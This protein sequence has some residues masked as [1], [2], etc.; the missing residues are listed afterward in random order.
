MTSSPIASNWPATIRRPRPRK[1]SQAQQAVAAFDTVLQA[2]PDFAPAHYGRGAALE[3]LGDREGAERHYRVAFELLPDYA[4][5]MAALAALLARTGR[6]ADA[7]PLAVQALTLN[8]ASVEAAMALAYADL[9]AG[10][11]KAAEASLRPLVART[12]LDAEL[13]AAAFVTLGDALDRDG[14]FDEAFAAYEDAVARLQKVRAT[15]AK[16]ID[17]ETYLDLIARLASWFKDATPGDWRP[18]TE[19]AQAPAQAHVFIISAVAYSGSNELRRVLDAHPKVAVLEGADAL[20]EA[21][22]RFLLAPDGFEQLATLAAAEAKVLRD[23]YWARTAEQLGDLKDKVVVDSAPFGFAT[24][25]L[26]AAL[27]PKA[28]II[29]ALRDPR[30][31]VLSNFQRPVRKNADLHA[32]LSLE[33]SAEIYDAGMRLLDTFWEKLPLEIAEAR[34]EDLIANGDEETRS[35]CAFLGVDWDAR[36]AEAA[37]SIVD[38]VHARIILS[39]WRDYGRQMAPLLS[40]LAPWVER[41]G[42]PEA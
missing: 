23:A 7:R 18:E 11:A 19:D 28:K 33:G 36:V 5:A 40:K 27:F 34:L 9:A 13:A 2:V 29:V 32:Y 21:Q 38:D 17:G 39:H 25:C 10:D 14:R 4:D 12:D 16:D 41:F 1:T 22:R 8:P 6:A 37:G 30:D 3:R 42:Y 35:L 20:A 15:V 26:I 31:A 24:L